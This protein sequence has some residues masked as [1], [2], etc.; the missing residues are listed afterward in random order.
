MREEYI[1][2]LTDNG[3]S[4]LAHSN[5]NKPTPC[6]YTFQVLSIEK[7]PIG[8]I[9]DGPERFKITLSDGQHYI[10]GLLAYK[11]N[12]IGPKLYENDVVGL[13]SYS[14]VTNSGKALIILN[15]LY[16]KHSGICENIGQPI[17][18]IF[19]TMSGNN[20][21][22]T[23]SKNN[24]P[25]PE[26]TPPPKLTLEYHSSLS[27]S[28]RPSSSL[29]NSFTIIDDWMV[30]ESGYVQG[31]VR[32]SYIAIRTSLPLLFAME[33][34]FELDK[35]VNLDSIDA[36]T[37]FVTTSGSC[38]ELGTKRDT[39]QLFEHVKHHISD[40]DCFADIPE[41]TIE[42]GAGI[43]HVFYAT[44]VKKSAGNHPN[45]LVIDLDDVAR[46]RLFGGT[47]EL[48]EIK[49]TLSRQLYLSLNPNKRQPPQLGDKCA[50]LLFGDVTID[51]SADRDLH[52]PYLGRFYLESEQME[53]TA[54]F[55]FDETINVV[56]FYSNLQLFMPFLEEEAPSPLHACVSTIKKRLFSDVASDLVP[57][58]N[59]QQKK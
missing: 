55:S 52:R 27:T 45:K 11:S 31:V 23:L 12:W 39:K 22:H 17:L 44:L 58:V 18:Y 3:V 6:S 7:G 26:Q 14:S 38:Y 13:S 9:D 25:P 41:P 33:N 36:Y 24:Q 28:S 42:Y 5:S 48:D 21:R 10:I 2:T 4:I 1:T 35:N 34:S 15:D 56:D 59:K 46:F 20:Q 53:P 54:F 29:H 32:E 43:A 51:P 8:S 40:F 50:L 57:T 47:I 16:I 19:S 49:Y 30:L 37:Y